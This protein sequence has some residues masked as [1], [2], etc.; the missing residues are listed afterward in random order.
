MD[1]SE[2]FELL[3]KLGAGSFATVYRARDRELG[4]EVAVK[5]IHSEYMSDSDQLERYWSEAQLL[6][7]LQH[8]NIV[9]IYDIDR[10]R[11]W[12]IME[13]MQANLSERLQGRPM[14][15]RALK[16]TVAHSLRALK[17]LHD[18]GILHGDIKPTNLMVDHRKRVKLGDFGL[19]RRVSDDDGSLLKGTTKYMA[20]EVL[21]EEWGEIGPSS[22]LYSIGFSAYELMCGSNFETLFPGLGAFGR[23]KQV[24]WMMWHAAKDRRLPPVN[25]VLEGVPEDLARVIDRLAEKDPAK[26]YQSA[27]EALKDLKVETKTGTTSVTTSMQPIQ[28]EPAADKEQKKR[29]MLAGGALAL[30]LIMSMAMLFWPS[31]N[32]GPAPD[33]AKVWFVSEV[34][35][36]SNELKVEDMERTFAEKIQ[37]GD[38]PRIKLTNTGRNILLEELQPGDLLEI[39]QR[40]DADGNTVTYV[41]ASRPVEATGRLER[42]NPTENSVTVA[43]ESGSTRD[44]LDARLIDGCEIILN[45]QISRKID[46]LRQGDVVTV[47]HLPELKGES[48]RII[49]YISA[50]RVVEQVGFVIGYDSIQRELTWRI[51]EASDDQTVSRKLADDV[52]IQV[53]GDESQQLKADQ[54][55]AGDRIKVRY[56]DVVREIVAFRDRRVSGLIRSV[57]EDAMTVSALVEGRGEMQFAIEDGTEITIGLEPAS[58]GDLRRDDAI[59]ISFRDLGD[60]E[61][62]A[63]V[64]D[65]RRTER[66]DRWGVVLTATRFDDSK[67][68]W[69]PFARRDAENL[70]GI[71]RKRYGIADSQLLVLTDQKR[72]TITKAIREMTPHLTKNSHLTVFVSVPATVSGD[73]VKLAVA[74]TNLSSLDDTAVSLQWLLGAL[75]DSSVG[76]AVVVTDCSRESNT[77]VFG[78]AMSDEKM[79]ESLAAGPA[80]ANVALIAGSSGEQIGL[81]WPEQESGVVGA[82]LKRAY[83]GEADADRDAR[84]SNAELAQFLEKEIPSVVVDGKMQSPV[85][86]K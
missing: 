3:E 40:P 65:A 59:E 6:A 76:E 11:G 72:D 12:L 31:G 7:S 33:Q 53:D 43:V 67:I 49:S 66:Y 61:F 86:V 68:R 39:E 23:D 80:N 70:T 32:E 75:R 41:T 60:E 55:G 62:A 16:T 79:L 77:A 63:R 5:Q 18:R 25:K 74:D 9:T 83:A 19:A 2:R 38:R 81:E 17:Y 64:I 14:D 34:F 51:G 45:G 4:R 29:L 15:L 46:D 13:L 58:I 71:L 48:G 84:I 54:L 27:G 37:L 57:D 44:N 78:S 24:A 42:V 10:G 22:D 56:D 36:D 50:T 82:V 8:P 85:T 69:R 47:R 1:F 30:S 21:S 28:D 52:T 73:D 26:R 20:P 35:T